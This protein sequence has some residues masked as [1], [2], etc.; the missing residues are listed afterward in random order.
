MRLPIARKE[1]DMPLINFIDT[2]SRY[3]DLSDSTDEL[4][5]EWVG[6][7]EVSRERARE[8]DS[9]RGWSRKTVDDRVNVAV[10]A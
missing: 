4:I 10:E 5:G 9:R 3:A 8:T 1:T 6:R 2:S 7:I